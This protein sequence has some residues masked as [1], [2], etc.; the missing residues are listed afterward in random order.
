MAME[1]KNDV[2]TGLLIRNKRFEFIAA[3]GGA[4]LH[5]GAIIT[6][7]EAPVQSPIMELKFFLCLIFD[8]ATFLSTGITV[9]VSV[10]LTIPRY[11]ELFD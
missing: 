8:R 7:V 1:R 9:F 10:F 4:Y 2:A 3:F 6:S 5:G 11:Q